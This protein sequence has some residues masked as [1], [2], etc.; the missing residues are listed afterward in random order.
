MERIYKNNN[1]DSYQRAVERVKLIKSFYYHLYVYLGINFLVILGKVVSN[2]F[3]GETFVQSFFELETFG[4]AILWGI[5]LAIHAFN[6]FGFNFLFGK[7]WEDLKIQQLMDE[8]S[9]SI[10][11]I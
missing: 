5:G 4:T 6:V 8:E 2:L 7:N 3:N 9:N 11:K 1:Q 10:R